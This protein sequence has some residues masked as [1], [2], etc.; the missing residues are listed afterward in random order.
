MQGHDSLDLAQVRVLYGAGRRR[1]ARFRQGSDGVSELLRVVLRARASEFGA[2]QKLIA[3]A[4]ELDEIANED[5]PDVP[6]M[7]GWRYEVFGNQAQ[8]LKAGKIA[9]SADGDGVKIVPVASN[10]DV[11]T[12]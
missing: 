4:A 12:D 8:R 9:L 1:A 7:R 10:G 2:A 3:N 5:Q 11:V 6:A